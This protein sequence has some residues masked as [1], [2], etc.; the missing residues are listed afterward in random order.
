MKERISFIKL[1]QSW[2]VIF[3]IGI[4][5]S[6]ITIDLIGS[7]RDF[8]FRADEMRTDHIAQQ[9]QMIK[10]EVERVVDMINHKRA[11]SVTL[12]QIKIK[13]RVYEAYSIAQNIYQQNK[14]AKSK[15]EIQQIILDAL[16]PIRFEM[17][18]SKLLEVLSQ[19]LLT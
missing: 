7:Y 15:D 17:T 18:L 6:I 5:A 12:T 8:N 16:K 19:V 9:K 13:A 3:L 4:G 10:R 2:G 14:A 11:R 1:I